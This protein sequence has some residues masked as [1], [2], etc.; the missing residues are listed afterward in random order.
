MEKEPKFN[1]QE[2]APEEE[3]KIIDGKKYRK[4]F[5][6]YT[7]RQFYSHEGPGWDL[8]QIQSTR[9]ELAKEYGIELKDLK[10]RLMFEPKDLPDEPYYQWELV[11]E[12]EQNG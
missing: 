9:E 12:E 4:V 3:I 2:S 11:D 6:G 10:D 5:S 8:F 7:V 1:Q